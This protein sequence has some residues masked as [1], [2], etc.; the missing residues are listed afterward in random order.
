VTAVSSATGLLAALRERPL[1]RF[2]LVGAFVTVVDFGVF[3]LVLLLAHEVSR[4]Y[5]L[6]ANTISFAIA[7]NV[8]YQMHARITFRSS[9][10]WRGFAAFGVVALAG[11]SIYNGALFLLLLAVDSNHPLALN[12]A[13]AGAVAVAAIWN[14]QGYRIFAF[15]GRRRARGRHRADVAA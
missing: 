10:D 6:L 11:V 1:V 4:P 14:Y 13:K 5:V 7:A 12:V 9:R 15:G 2:A 3:N 8:G